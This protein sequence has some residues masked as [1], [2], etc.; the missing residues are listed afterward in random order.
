[1]KQIL[2]ISGGGRPGG[3]TAQLTAA[4]E[5]GADGRSPDGT[6]IPNKTSP[7]LKKPAILK[8]RTGLG[9][10]YIETGG[11]SVI[12]KDDNPSYCLPQ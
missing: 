11:L 2:I 12:F 3:N 6:C 4:F 7:R 5:R 8:G 9:N 1:M 10:R